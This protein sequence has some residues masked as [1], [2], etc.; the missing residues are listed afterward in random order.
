M[1]TWQ[2]KKSKKESESGGIKEKVKNETPK[3]AKSISKDFGK[4][5]YQKQSK[6]ARVVKS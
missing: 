3:E 5:T 2:A 1:R 4:K 6:P